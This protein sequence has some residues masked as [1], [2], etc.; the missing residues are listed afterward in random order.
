MHKTHSLVAFIP[1]SLPNRRLH[2]RKIKQRSFSRLYLVAASS[3]SNATHKTNLVVSKK[4]TT[5]FAVPSSKHLTVH[6]HVKVAAAALFVVA[7]SLKMKAIVDKRRRRK[8]K[9]VVVIGGGFAGMQCVFDL[10]KKCDLTL[11]DAKTYFEYTPGALSAM[12]GGGP[13]RKYGGSGK[14]GARIG[15]LHREYKKICT[16]RGA[17]FVHCSDEGVKNIC[18]DYVSVV[19]NDAPSGGVCEKLEYDYLVIATGSNYFRTIKPMGGSPGADAQTGYA[20]Q[21]AFQRDATRLVPESSYTEETKKPTLVIGGGV[22]GIELAA[23]IASAAG[24]NA[25]K[26]SSG[27]VILVHD[28]NR[29]LNGLPKAASDYVEN[30]FKQKKVRIELGQRFERVKETCTYVGSSDSNVKLEANEAIL[31]VGS[32]PATKFL[33]FEN[34]ETLLAAAEAKKN[35]EKIL[36]IPL[37]KNGYI[38]RDPKTLQVVGFENIYCVGDCAMKP[39]EQNLASFAHWEAEYVSKR[40]LNIKSYVMNPYKVPPKFMAISLGP[41][42]G[43]FLWGDVLLLKGILAAVLKFFVEVWFSNFMPSLYTMVSMLPRFQRDD[44]EGDVIRSSVGSSALRPT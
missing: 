43:L 25:R 3:R 17:R 23:D 9:K 41:W 13:L 20:R 31:A 22:V 39:L 8:K 38:E 36:E 10:A 18:E 21:Q 26:S 11:V 40:I 32:R 42:N 12:V 35:G 15:R 34:Q 7:V 29:L 6:A 14:S 2:A 30:W 19:S 24:S 1:S 33:S 44:L 16:K 37:S 5:S 27:A 28:K 4:S